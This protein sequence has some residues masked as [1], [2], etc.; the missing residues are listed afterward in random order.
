MK[1]VMKKALIVG[2]IASS[3]S[4]SAFAAEDSEISILGL[5]KNGKQIDLPVG[6]RR[7]KKRMAK[8]LK[9]FNGEA[10]PA[11]DKTIT[12]DK[13]F[14]LRQVDI[15]V[16]IKMALGLGDLLKGSLEPGIK[17]KFGN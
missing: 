7:Y 13:K 2:L 11:L 1:N 15:G 8:V 9:V 10:I 12:S 17:L 14:A 4:G 16:S 6:T 5:D 3:F